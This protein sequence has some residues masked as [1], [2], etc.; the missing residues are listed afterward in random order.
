MQDSVDEI[1]AS[2]EMMSLRHSDHLHLFKR[3]CAGGVAGCVAKTAVAPL[4]RVVVLMQVQSMRP[5]KFRDGQTPNNQYLLASL[6]KIISEEGAR[7]L[8]RGNGATVV[9]RFPY[10]GITFCVNGSL[11]RHLAE[12]PWSK[13]VPREAHSFISGGCGAGIAIVI[14]YPL[15]VVKT[16]LT[17]QTRTMYYKGILDAFYKIPRDEGMHGLYR[18]LSMSVASIVPTHAFN[19]AFYERFF[20]LYSGL[21]APCVEILA[22]GSSGALS[23][24]LL[25]PLDLLRRQMQMVGVGGR[26]PVYTSVFQAIMHVFNTGARR[27]EALPLRFLYGYREFFRGLLPELLKVTPMSAIMFCVHDKLLYARWPF[28]RGR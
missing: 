21:D 16:R 26:P 27:S 14:C 12:E 2:L 8:W 13:L 3:V 28:E 11:R 20:R 24:T 23:A 4:S 10:T 19:F 9:H 7:G 6:R 17:T 18:G 22:G 15:D 1:H 5:Q 25:F